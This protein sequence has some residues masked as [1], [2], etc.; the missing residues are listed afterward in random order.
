[1]TVKIN[2]SLISG[3][4][5]APA[6]KSAMQRACALALLR[7]GETIISNPGKSNDDLAAVEVIKNLGAVIKFLNNNRLSIFSKGFPSNSPLVGGGWEGAVNCGESGL[8]L[9][10]FAPIAALSS[11]QIILNGTGSLLQRPMNFFDEIFP[12]LQV[13]VETNNGKLPIKIK[14]ALQPAD[15]TIDGSLSSQFLTGLL[16]AY[17]KAC[18]APVSIKVNHLKSKPYIDLTLQM[19]KHFGWDVENRNY[20]EFYF[21][22]GKL[23]KVS[24]VGGDLAGAYTVEGD[25]SGGAFLLVAG[26]IA[27]SVT[28][29][30][31]NVF[32]AQADKKILEALRTSGAVLSI[33]E[34][35]IS[36]SSAPLKAIQ[37]N[38]THCPD[39]FP[40]LVALT[41]YCKGKS[42]IEGV[43]RLAHKE[44]NRAITLQTEFAR[45]GINILLQ[46]DLMIIEGNK[47]LQGASISSHHDHRI[48]MA[49]AVAALQAKGETIIHDA[50]AINKSYPDFY[51]HLQKLNA[52]LQKT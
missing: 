32:S 26:A 47:Q 13:Q 34:E 14:G 20:E 10:M 38:A 49:C 16:M 8:G 43:S 2:P 41:A 3:T 45:M 11:Q 52:N 48:A 5:H 19:M 28:V 24:S 15:I 35:E 44:S 37:F 1:M 4:I 51:N 25:W 6:S 18:T 36:V 21:D 17:A 31:L 46:D 22:P 39:L 50:E 7:E 27:G 40:P 30:G 42:V 33:S 23:S 9:R 29:K 12:L